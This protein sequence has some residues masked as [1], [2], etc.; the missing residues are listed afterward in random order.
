MHL[1]S[2]D[3]ICRAS[4][5]IYESMPPTP[6]YRWPLLS[7]RVGTE[8]WLKHESHNPL[9]AFKMRSALVY[10]RNLVDSGVTPRCAVAATR[11]NYGQAVAFAARRQGIEPVLYVPHGNSV[12]KN[13]AMRSLGATLVEHGDDF[14]QARQESVRWAAANGHHC[15]PSFHPWLT[16]GTAT[17]YHELFSQAPSIDVLY[18][19]IG[20]GSGICGAAA[21]RAVLGLSTELVGVCSAHAR[22]QYD[23]FQRREYIA[24]PSGTRIA[25]GLA[26]PAPDRSAL[27]LIWAHV[28]R[29]LMV[30]DDEVMGAMRAIYDDTHTVAEGGGASGLAAILQD[31]ERIRGRRVATVITGGNVDRELF[32]EVL[33]G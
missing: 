5:T 22:A 15:V 28:S 21:A 33:R 27:E 17:L 18:V 1:P 11:G 24:S 8:V 30:T 3:R 10:F 25:D 29:I 23:A 2:A 31:R 20:M 13:R 26:V 7:E 32:A 19:P 12:S 16:E 14:E 9:G 4:Q 6:Q